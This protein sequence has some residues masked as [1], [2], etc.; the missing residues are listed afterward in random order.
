MC[1]TTQ[2]A[3][4]LVTG[5]DVCDLIRVNDLERLDCLEVAGLAELLDRVRVDV[6]TSSLVYWQ[7]EWGVRQAGQPRAKIGRSLFTWTYPCG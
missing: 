3:A 6:E 7:S 2:R 5:R 1:R 4:H